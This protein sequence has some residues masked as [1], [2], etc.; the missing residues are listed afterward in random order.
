MLRLLLK[1]L[2]CQWRRMTCFFFCAS[3]LR[4]DC[5][6]MLL[7]VR[8]RKK[9]R[10]WWQHWSDMKAIGTTKSKA[11][12]RFFANSLKPNFTRCTAMTCENVASAFDRLP[13]TMDISSIQA[14]LSVWKCGCHAPT[15]LYLWIA[16]P[17]L[18]FFAKLHKSMP[19]QTA[20]NK[21]RVFAN[22]H[23]S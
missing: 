16:V 15:M 21:L 14:T 4:V 13:S 22:S 9:F 2:C 5:E 19:H 20:I 3:G 10:L 18:H 17:A 23:Q 8:Q 6:M 7:P 11:K 1:L 12:H